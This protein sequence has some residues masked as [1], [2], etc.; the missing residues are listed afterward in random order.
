MSATAT[1]APASATIGSCSSG[2]ARIDYGILERTDRTWAS[3]TN[4]PVERQR[5]QCYTGLFIPPS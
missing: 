2:G 1:T 5:I 3:D 4:D